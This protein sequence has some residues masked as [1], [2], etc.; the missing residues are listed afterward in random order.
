LVFLVCGGVT[1]DGRSA[2]KEPGYAY[3]LKDEEMIGLLGTTRVLI[4]E[5]GEMRGICA[6]KTKEAQEKYRAEQEAREKKEARLWNKVL[7]KLGR[8]RPKPQEPQ[9]ATQ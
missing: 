8:G 3:A 2:I 6:H 1:L 4:M 5:E 7:N 9:C